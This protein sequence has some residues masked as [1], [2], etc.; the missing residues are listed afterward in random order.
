MAPLEHR[1]HP[2]ELQPPEKL[3]PHSKEAN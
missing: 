2:E 1:A 3:Q